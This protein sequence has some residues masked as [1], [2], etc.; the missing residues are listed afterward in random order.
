MAIIAE[1]RLHGDVILF[2]ETFERAPNAECTFEGFH[3]VTGEEDDTHYVFFWWMTGSDDVTFGEALETDPSVKAHR[4]LTELD[5]RTLYRIRTRSFQSDRPLVFPEFRKND[6]SAI[7]SKRDADG[8]HLKARFPDRNALESFVDAAGDIARRVDTKRL[9]TD[10]GTVIDET[11]LTTKQREALMLALDRGYFDTP[12]TAT[13][14]DL[15]AE[16]DVTPQTLSDH[17]RA[18]VKKLVERA[19][20]SGTAIDAD[21]P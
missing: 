20:A 6:I 5:D 15:A 21:G 7:E 14:A 2:G 11:A 18:G 1:L 8:L 19:V 3:Y 16:R 13:L 10:G 17:V 4:V 9:Y 12:S